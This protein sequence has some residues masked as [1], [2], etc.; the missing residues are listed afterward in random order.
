MNATIIDLRYKMKDVLRMIDQGEAVTVLYRGKPKAML[1]P[2]FVDDSSSLTRVEEQ[3]AF[4]MWKDNAAMADP[5]A[6]V[7]KLR[8][9]RFASRFADPKPSRARKRK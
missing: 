1:T 2:I 9:P 7:R 6:Y 4:G 8:E 3:P 5:D